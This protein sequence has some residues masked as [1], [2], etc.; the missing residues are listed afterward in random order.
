[1]E[2][3]HASFVRDELLGADTKQRSA[4]YALP[5]GVGTMMLAARLTKAG[6]GRVTI[7][8][9]G[10]AGHD[11]RWITRS[12]D[13]VLAE[14]KDRSYDAGLR[15]SPEK[16]VRRV[17]DE[18]RKSK[19]PTD[20]GACRIL[21]V[22]F[23]HLVTAAKTPAWDRLYARALKP[24]KLSRERKRLPHFILVEHLG[25][26]ARTAGEKSNFFWP[27]AIHWNAAAKRIQPLLACAIGFEG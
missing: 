15:D 4:E 11:I 24:F 2:Q 19:I 18:V 14:R 26:E 13:L 9:S 23:Q 7:H 5:A 22:G 21:S 20:P 1:M 27:H 10:V 8:G 16:R 25:L 3:I 12:S 17:Q 6:G